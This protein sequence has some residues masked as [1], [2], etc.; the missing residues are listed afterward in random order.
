MITNIVRTAVLTGL[1]A[2]TLTMTTYAGH[3]SNNRAELTG[4]AGVTGH[5]IVNYV[6]GTEGWASTVS[7]MGLP[8][9]IYTFVVRL[10]TGAPQAI[11]SF[12]VSG[13]GRGGCSDND[14]ALMG[15]N[16]ALIVDGND[17]VVAGGV[18]VRRG[19]NRGQ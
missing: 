2:L 14:A 18:F 12:E 15:F 17:V 9:G 19:G 13:E 6:K 16:Q 1:A 5:A 8:D 10:N 3:E 4:V 7:V 11:C